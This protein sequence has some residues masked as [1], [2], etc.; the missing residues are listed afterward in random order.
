VVVRQGGRD[1][2]RELL[3]RRLAKLDPK[4]YRDR[5]LQNAAAVLMADDE[6]FDLEAL[7]AAWERACHAL[8]GDEEP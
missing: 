5:V 4:S 3:G 2:K 6:R 7:K 8:E 1:W